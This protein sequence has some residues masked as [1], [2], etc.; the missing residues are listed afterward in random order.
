MSRNPW[1]DDG[2]GVG[3]AWPGKDLNRGQARADGGG[4]GIGI[5][6]PGGHPGQ[7][8]AVVA[9]IPGLVELEFVVEILLAEEREQGDS[10][11]QERLAFGVADRLGR[12]VCVGVVVV[13]YRHDRT[14][15]SQ[16][17]ERQRGGRS[18]RSTTPDGRPR[19]T[20]RVEWASAT[21]WPCRAR[22]FARAGRPECRA[23]GGPACRRL[24]RAWLHRRP[25]GR[26]W[27]RRSR[28]DG[29]EGVAKTAPP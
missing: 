1:A 20:G 10:P 17:L 6:E 16:R 11:A 4:I 9:A 13:V 5:G 28:A 3:R 21:G 19:K 25:C 7:E 26:A 27:Q 18:L 2:I 24:P 22:P 29:Q 8:R 23:S 14:A 12:K 15:P